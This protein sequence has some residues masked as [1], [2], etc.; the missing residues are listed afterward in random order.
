M[1]IK[2]WKILIQF[3]KI[4]VADL[5]WRSL[6]SPRE[7]SFQSSGKIRFWNTWQAFFFQLPP[8][9]FIKMDLSD[10]NALQNVEDFTP[11]SQCIWR[12]SSLPPTQGRYIIDR[13]F[14]NS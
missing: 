9:I 6:L 13:L 5:E 14:A 11:I 2:Q 4:L 8:N 12:Y 1:F 10:I 7:A 3:C